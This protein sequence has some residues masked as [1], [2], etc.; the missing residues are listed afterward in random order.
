MLISDS[1]YSLLF[2]SL[3]SSSSIVVAVLT[4]CFFA[5]LTICRRYDRI[6]ADQ[7]VAVS[8]CRQSDL[9]PFW[10][11]TAQSIAIGLGGTCVGF[12][13]TQL[14]VGPNPNPNPKW[15]DRKLV[16]PE[17]DTSP[18]SAHTQPGQALPLHWLK[19]GNRSTHHY[20]LA[21]LKDSQN[22]IRLIQCIVNA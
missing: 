14:P 4:S 20:I 21:F 13:P 2:F 19:Y 7:V 9:S 8:A 15:I 12:G 22:N 3:P 1:F 16:G 5:I 18:V 17:F 11:D 10:P 6:V